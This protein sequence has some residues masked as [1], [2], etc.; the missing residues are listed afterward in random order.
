MSINV[1]LWSTQKWEETLGK[2]VV[3]AEKINCPLEEGLEDLE[4]QLRTKGESKIWQR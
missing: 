4:K 2:N 1:E 3:D